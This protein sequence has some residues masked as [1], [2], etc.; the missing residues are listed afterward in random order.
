MKV[1][2]IYHRADYD[3]LFQEALPDWAYDLGVTV[4][5]TEVLE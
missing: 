3:G 2:V 1:N 4:T 5:V